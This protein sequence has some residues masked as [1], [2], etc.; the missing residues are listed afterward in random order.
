MI[1]LRFGDFRKGDY[2]EEDGYH[3]LYVVK[4]LEE[5]LYIGIS[6]QG[7]WRRWF[8]DFWGHFAQGS[9]IA[10]RIQE[11]SPVSNDWTIDLWTLKDCQI[12][13]KEE[14]KLFGKRTHWSI[15]ACE[16]LMIRK[17]RP[18]LN[19]EHNQTVNAESVDEMSQDI[20]DLYGGI[21]DD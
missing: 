13:L 15:E 16:Q 19:I 4:N 3:E 14:L 9:T 10:R 20:E 5:V 2:E 8:D 12:L 6:Q 11:N 7:I 1:S 18:R 17:M 21:Q